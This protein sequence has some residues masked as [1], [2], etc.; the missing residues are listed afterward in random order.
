MARNRENESNQQLHREEDEFT[1]AD[2]DKRQ[3]TT[4]RNEHRGKR[5]AGTNRKAD[6]WWA[7]AN[8]QNETNSCLKL[9]LAE[10]DSGR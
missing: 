9:R 1:V 8:R 6:G 3:Q 2:E 5:G 10:S 7:E 4:T